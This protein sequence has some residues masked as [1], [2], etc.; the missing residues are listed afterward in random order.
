[1]PILPSR[2]VVSVIL[3]GLVIGLLSVFALVVVGAVQGIP[4]A[5]SAAGVLL[6][7]VII[8]AGLSTVALHWWPA[9]GVR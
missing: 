5:I 1:M 9:A 7:A 3:P 4:L 2:V 6:V 8:V